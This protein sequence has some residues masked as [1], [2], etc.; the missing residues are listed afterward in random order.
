MAVFSCCLTVGPL[1]ARIDDPFYVAPDSR[2]EDICCSF[3]V[4]SHS[5]GRVRFA[6]SG[7]NCC[8]VNDPLHLV[9]FDCPCQCLQIHDV[10]L[11]I[12]Y[13]FFY[14]AEKKHIFVTRV[15]DSLHAQFDEPPRD[16]G[17]DAPHSSYYQD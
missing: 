6:F 17:A 14:V 12:D 2:F 7:E 1:G 9:V 5:Q 4:H 16:K 15:N 10:A 13:L 11:G 3:H 8:H